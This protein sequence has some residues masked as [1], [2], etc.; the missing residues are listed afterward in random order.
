M[1]SKRPASW[2]R[3]L[4]GLWLWMLLTALAAAPAHA[5]I[6]A[7]DDETDAPAAAPGAEATEAPDSGAETQN[8]RGTAY[9]LRIEAPRDLR[10]LLSRHLDLSRF[11]RERD[12]TEVEVG[13]LMSAAP[14]QTR[15]LLETQGYFN[16]RVDISRQPPSQ[17]GGTPL[18]VLKVEPGPLA[19]VDRLTLEIQGDFQEAAEEEGSQ[20]ARRARFLRNRW[21]LQPGTP[22]TQAAWTAAKNGLLASLRSRGYPA[23]SYAGTAAQVDATTNKVRI[24]VVADSGP[25]FRI[26]EIRVEGI[27]RTTEEAVRNLAPFDLGDTFSEKMLLDYQESLQKSGLYE[28]VAVELDPDVSRADSAPIIVRVREAK[29][30]S[31]TVSVGFSSNTGPRVGL[32][33]THRRPFGFEWVASTRLL[34]GRD[35]RVAA[36]D[37]LS[38]PK[39]DGY[40]NL[41]TLS[42][43]YLAAGGAVTHTQRARYGRTQDTERVDR[44]YYGELNRTV[45]ETDTTRRIDRAAWANYEWTRRDVNNVLFPTRGLILTA[46]GGG[47]VS[48]DS[49]GDRG[50]FLRGYLRTTWYY[51]L[52]QRRVLQLRG[53]AGQVFKRDSLGVPDTLLF[54]AGGDDSVRGYGYR[55]L[56]PERDGAVVGGPVMATA[57]AELMW[58]LSSRLRDWYGAVF[59]DVGNA[60][61]SWRDFDAARGYG[62]GVRWRSPIGPLKADVAYGEATGK[63]RV[64]LS[65]GVSF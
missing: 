2:T 50:P 63:V 42:S 51:P 3:L 4:S 56:G 34:Y 30:K 62:A 43:E 10:D 45:V 23:A 55:T 36:L 38:Y 54:R 65:V 6:A 24:F 58:P 41:A 37:L 32:Q 21:P 16:A 59:V 52:G 49:D 17:A 13:R 53:E 46:H 48:S 61:N 44:L 19:Q 33:F 14:A 8:G 31:A 57:S 9:Q 28:G 26:G 40:R 29:M 35:E 22:F 18:V 1:T 64:H 47:G 27:E 25:L 11:R 60:A 39:P 15:A 20:E 7:D 5:Q 12:I